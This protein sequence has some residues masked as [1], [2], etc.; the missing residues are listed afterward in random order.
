[1]K[2]NTVDALLVAAL[3]VTIFNLLS[4]MDLKK[5]PKII[6]AAVTNIASTVNRVTAKQKRALKNAMKYLSYKLTYILLAFQ[7][8]LLYLYVLQNV[9]ALLK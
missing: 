1:M 5:C 2:A 8:I 4:K 3:L 9:S 6:E 7:Y